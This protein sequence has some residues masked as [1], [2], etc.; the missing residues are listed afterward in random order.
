MAKWEA[1]NRVL[2]SVAQEQQN[3]IPV[4][5]SDKALKLDLSREHFIDIVTKFLTAVHT[6]R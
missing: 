5:L 2:A 6:K 4:K 3:T 1:V